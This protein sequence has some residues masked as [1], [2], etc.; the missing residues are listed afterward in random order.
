MAS[1]TAS[2]LATVQ[3]KKT[4]IK[5]PV[6]PRNPV[7]SAMKWQSKTLSNINKTAALVTYRSSRKNS[8][9]APSAGEQTLTQHQHPPSSWCPSVHL[10]L[11]DF[12]ASFIGELLFLLQCRVSAVIPVVLP[13]PGDSGLRKQCCF[14]FWLPN[15]RR[16]SFV[17][18]WHLHIWMKNPAW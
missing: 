10:S 8:G 5:I 11:F 9:F 4:A 14:L 7:V 18:Y 16:T 15:G 1:A 17:P 6:G 13:L 12:S 2:G 3:S